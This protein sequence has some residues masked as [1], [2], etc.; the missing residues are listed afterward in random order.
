MD[1]WPLLT[2][3]LL[4]GAYSIERQ[5][6]PRITAVAVRSD[7]LADARDVVIELCTRWAGGFSPLVVVDAVAAAFDDRT[8]KVLLGSNID[9]LEGRQLLPKETEQKYSDRWANASQWLLRQITELK[10]RPLVQTCR[11]V[12]TNHTWYPAY[13]AMFGDVP[14]SPNYDSNRRNDLRA[15]LSFGDLVDTKP[16]GTEPS[17]TD[18]LA[19][20]RDP[21]CI[22]AVRLTRI[23]LPTSIIAGYNKGLPSTSRFTWGQSLAS[24]R[25]GPN[26]LVVYEPGSVEDLVLTWNLRA[27]FAHP[28]KLPLAVPLTDTIHDDLAVLSHAHEAQHFFGFGHNLGS[29]DVVVGR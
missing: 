26:L 25:Y 29:C 28:P 6:R 11:D 7:S 12:P 8:L 16:F 19:R 27:R 5:L 17:V 22:S 21:Q 14:D 18:L 1:L 2:E 3:D 9:G 20:I 13:L 15:D 24:T 10:Y 4:S 23:R